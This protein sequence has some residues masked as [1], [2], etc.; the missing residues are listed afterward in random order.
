MD[1]E[2]PVMDG[3]AATRELRRVAGGGPRLP[4]IA[5]T[6]DA[7]AEA[8]AACADAG[9]DDYLTKPFTRE[10]LH[11]TLARWLPAAPAAAATA[12][13]QTAA[14]PPADPGAELLLDRATLAALRALPARGSRD[15]L[16]H[17]ATGYLADSQEMLLRI[18]RAVHN[19]DAAELARAAHAWRSCSG[20]ELE[21]CGRAGDLAGAPELLTQLRAL[22]PRVCEELDDEIR[23]SA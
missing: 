1:C 8:R 2:M 21:K 12:A 7:T 3:L 13:P 4:V 23:K 5:S 15:M 17:I 11:A 10:A 14:A 16:S 18:E 22:Y 19:R 9:M 20:R 6:A